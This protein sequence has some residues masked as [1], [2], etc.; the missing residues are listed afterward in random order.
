MMMMNNGIGILID[1]GR[2]GSGGQGSAGASIGLVVAG[3]FVLIF[4]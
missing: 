4:I 2:G 3:N 1:I